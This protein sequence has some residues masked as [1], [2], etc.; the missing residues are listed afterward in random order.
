MSFIPVAG[1][2][3]ALEGAGGAERSEALPPGPP[4]ACA[5]GSWIA[6]L[7]PSVSQEECRPVSAPFILYTLMFFLLQV[8]PWLKL[9]GP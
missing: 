9:P 4:M 5:R 7:C 1:G 3:G 6:C 2:R 8:K